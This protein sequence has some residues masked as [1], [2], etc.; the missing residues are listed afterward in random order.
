MPKYHKPRAGAIVVGA[1]CAIG[2]CAILLQDVIATQTI[3]IDHALQVLILVLSIAFGQVAAGCFQRGWQHWPAGVLLGFVAL[4]ASVWCIYSTAGRTGAGFDTVAEAARIYQERRPAL[5]AKIAKQDAMLEEE[6]TAYARQCATGKGTRCDGI[7]ASLEVYESAVRDTRRELD[8]LRP[9]I[10]HPRAH[11]MAAMVAA[12]LPGVDGEGLARVLAIFEPIVPSVVFELGAM[13]CF[14]IG[15]GRRPVPALAVPAPV[16]PVKPRKRSK[17]D[18]DADKV[19]SFC[20]AYRAK[21]GQ[22]PSTFDVAEATGIP[23]TTAWRLMAKI[24]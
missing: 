21:H 14:H 1:L 5:E 16:P 7:K 11:T 10:A 12:V 4:L 3:T 2:A 6:R 15:L 13:L 24:A 20:A 17:K 22:Q 8:G 18:M 23:R 9:V 19:S